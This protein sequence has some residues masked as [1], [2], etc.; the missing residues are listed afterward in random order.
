MVCPQIGNL[1]HGVFA[2][3]LPWA[4]SA[5]HGRPGYFVELGA[6]DGGTHLESPT[7]VLERCHGWTGLLIEAVPQTFKLLR[8][9]E[10]R[11]ATKVHAAV[12]EEGMNVTMHAMRNPT[13]G[14]AAFKEFSNRA[15]RFKWRRHYERNNSGTLGKNAG[16]TKAP[17]VVDTSTTMPCR[18]LRSIMAAANLPFAHLLSLD[19]Q[20]AELSV[21]RTVDPAIFSIVL[22]EMEG[23]DRKKDESVRE[24]L[25]LAGLRRQI[26]VKESYRLFGDSEPN[27]LWARPEVVDLMN[28]TAHVG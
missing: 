3:L 19:V 13:S 14:L 2:P 24:M 18:S 17:L 1:K 7:A 6:N 5:A 15:Y 9:N 25:R 26:D 12:C 27:E 16:T 11:A 28:R 22:V 10:L 8:D 20:G 4:L 23:I 21:L